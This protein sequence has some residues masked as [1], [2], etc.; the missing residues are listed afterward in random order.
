LE[1]RVAAFMCSHDR[2]AVTKAV[3]AV[4]LFRAQILTLRPTRRYSP[5]RVL[6]TPV[7]T[8]RGSLRRGASA[9]SA[10]SNTRERAGCPTSPSA[11]ATFSSVPGATSSRG[12]VK[13]D[14]SRFEV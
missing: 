5:G 11:G 9:T 7:R 13:K 1:A 4:R 12:P 8:R 10:G 6:R 3:R 2:R 14:D